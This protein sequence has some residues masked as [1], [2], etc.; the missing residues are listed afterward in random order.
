MEREA[1]A[2]LAL[3]ETARRPRKNKAGVVLK[4][5]KPYIYKKEK[6]EELIKIA[7]AKA[8][9][10]QP[11]N[12]LELDRLLSQP[13]AVARP[14]VQASSLP[15][16]ILEGRLESTKKDGV[17]AKYAKRTFAL[18]TSKRALKARVAKHLPVIPRL[19]AGEEEL[20]FYYTLAHLQRKGLPHK[21]M[22]L[23]ER[24]DI[25]WDRYV[26]G[27]YGLRRQQFISTLIQAAHNDVLAKSTNKT[28]MYWTPDMFSTYVLANEVILRIVG[29]DTG[30]D[31]GA[32]EKL[33]RE[34]A[35]Y[36]CHLADEI[37]LEDDLDFGEI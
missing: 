1:K 17:R 31:R 14:A 4:G 23:A 37:E 5:K 27:F 10:V 3:F 9:A 32:V 16:A 11:Q 26:C 15:N 18:P 20:S 2:P 13:V 24:W 36:G 34:T 12:F 30:L 6:Q 29:E 19:L 22:T 28:I 7:P 21:T 25:R 8:P 33:M 35:D